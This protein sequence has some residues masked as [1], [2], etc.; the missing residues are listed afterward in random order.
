MTSQV[1]CS[2]LTEISRRPSLI[3]ASYRHAQSVCCNLVLHRLILSQQKQTKN[4]LLRVVHLSSSHN[5]LQLQN[6]VSQL[7]YG[8][9]FT[10]NQGCETPLLTIN[11]FSPSSETVQKTND[12]YM[13]NQASLWICMSHLLQKICLLFAEVFHFGSQLSH[14]SM[15]LTQLLW[16]YNG[17]G[18]VRETDVRVEI[19][20]SFTSLGSDSL[21]DISVECFSCLQGKSDESGNICSNAL[22][23][24]W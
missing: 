20:I 10:Y 5:V 13:H 7:R 2:E 15:R 8:H 24:H 11:F 21:A 18:R 19:S 4:K 6:Q 14:F 16:T 9:L 23:K 12:G 1:V 17:Q 3:P 22:L